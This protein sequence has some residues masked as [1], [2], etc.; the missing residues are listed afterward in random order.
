MLFHEMLLRGSC[1]RYAVSIFR[2]GR[3]VRTAS[4][5]SVSR[6]SSNLTT[7]GLSHPSIFSRNSIYL[8]L[9]LNRCKNSLPNIPTKSVKRSRPRSSLLST[10]RL[11]DN[12]CLSTD[13]RR[14]SPRNWIFR[15]PSPITM[16]HWTTAH[17]QLLHARNTNIPASD[18]QYPKRPTF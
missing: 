2:G 4:A 1:V 16:E 9:R 8:T 7:I 5:S 6:I 13:S 14:S 12:P 3:D 11:P 18:N 10:N 17:A 15:K